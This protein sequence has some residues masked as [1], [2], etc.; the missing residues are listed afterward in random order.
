[1]NHAWGSV[2]P[3]PCASHQMGTQLWHRALVG[4]AIDCSKK[5][6]KIHVYERGER[7]LSFGGGCLWKRSIL[8]LQLLAKL[9]QEKV[10]FSLHKQ[11]CIYLFERK[12]KKKREASRCRVLVRKKRSVVSRTLGKLFKNSSS[13][14]KKSSLFVYQ[15]QC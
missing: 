1:M 2:L 15:W 6:N 12:K 8:S 11:Q 9:L 3:L 13:L 10:E 4:D 14:C 5:G 7:A